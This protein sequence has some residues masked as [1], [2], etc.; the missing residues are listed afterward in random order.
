MQISHDHQESNKTV[1]IVL[2]FTDNQRNLPIVVDKNGAM[3]L[4]R[5]GHPYTKRF[6]NR[7]SCRQWRKLG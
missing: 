5:D 6:E 2:R 4:I 7:W 3:Y 1:L